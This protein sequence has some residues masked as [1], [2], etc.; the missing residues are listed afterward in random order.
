VS[1]TK[2]FTRVEQQDTR[3]FLARPQAQVWEASRG[4]SCSDY[5]TP[6]HQ[7]A[8]ASNIPLSADYLLLRDTAGLQTVFGCAE[9]P[10]TSSPWLIS[11]C[12]AT[13]HGEFRVGAVWGARFAST[14]DA[15]RK[16]DI[17]AGLR[18]FADAV[19]GPGTY[20][21]RSDGDRKMMSDN[22]LS[23]VADTIGSRS[24]PVFTKPNTLASLL[25]N[26]G[27]SPWACPQRGQN[28]G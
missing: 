5:K 7:V 8:H 23:A 20:D 12:S 21:R 16:D 28:V 9:R 2:G 19:G 11:R 6:P 24:R 3:G 15:F 27:W 18:L 10:A 14:R 1:S 13:T 22:A 4:G 26:I 17:D 25:S